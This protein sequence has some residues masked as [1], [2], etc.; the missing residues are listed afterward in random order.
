VLRMADCQAR[1]S[2][3]LDAV[4][5]YEL[6]AK[7]ASE[8]GQKKLESIANVNEATQQQARGQ[9]PEALQLY[10]HALQLDES[11]GDRSAS[12]EDWLA[13]GR[14][15]EDAGF[16]PQLAY[17]CFVKAASLKDALPDPSQRQYVT[18]ATEQV[19]QRIGKTAAAIRTNPEPV[20]HEALAL[21]R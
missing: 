1:V 4:E 20:L 21:K 9:S 12:A 7:I 19:A 16:P 15:L 3:T 8:T 17:A 6:A 2:R 5:S 11:V 14:F 13:F 18:N 10:Q